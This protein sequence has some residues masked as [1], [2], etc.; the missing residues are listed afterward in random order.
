MGNRACLMMA[1]TVTLAAAVILANA[2]LLLGGAASAADNPFDQLKGDWT[3]GGPVSP[4]N[5]KPGSVTCKASYTAAGAAA[6]QAL[7]CTGTDYNIDSKIKLTLNG[8]KIKGTW[9]ESTYDANG[10]VT[11]TAKDGTIHARIS[12]D[13]FSGRMSIKTSDKGQ[14]INIL[15]LD[16]NS[17]AYRP[18]AA[19]SLQR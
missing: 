1:K 5:G 8:G 4:V 17:G 18:V 6:T 16:P 14:T 7:H 15:Q 13:K 11:G 9:S 3:G 19:L 2:P 12:G 10:G